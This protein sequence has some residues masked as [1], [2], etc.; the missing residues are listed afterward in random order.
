MWLHCEKKSK[1]CH[2]KLQQ[3]LLSQTFNSNKWLSTLSADVFMNSI[4][5]LFIIIGELMGVQVVLR[6]AFQGHLNCA[7]GCCV[8]SC[9]LRCSGSASLIEIGHLAHDFQRPTTWRSQVSGLGTDGWQATSEWQAT[10]SGFQLTLPALRE[11]WVACCV[12][13]CTYD[14]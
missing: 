5:C 1:V 6:V 2:I 3:L 4:I 14:Q 10:T 12:A 11:K 7:C 13:Y 9:K 8:L